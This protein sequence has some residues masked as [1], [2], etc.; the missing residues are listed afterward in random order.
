M[1]IIL[2]GWF[3]GHYF[4]FNSNEEQFIPKKQLVLN[5]FYIWVGCFIFS[6][7]FIFLF[8]SFNDW[9][10]NLYEK[11]QP[12]SLLTFAFEIKNDVSFNFWESSGKKWAMF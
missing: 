9:F 10:Y 3:I 1:F 5:Q 2:V 7:L 4:D 11:E 8:F 12:D 6:N